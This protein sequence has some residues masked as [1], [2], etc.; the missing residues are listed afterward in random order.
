MFRPKDECCHEGVAPKTLFHNN[1]LTFILIFL[2]NKL[3]STLF[4]VNDLVHGTQ[5]GGIFVA[6]A[7]GVKVLQHSVSACYKY[8]DLKAFEKFNGNLS[9]QNF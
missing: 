1:R 8:F 7:L 3:P 4:T 6:T 9:L 5:K 2:M